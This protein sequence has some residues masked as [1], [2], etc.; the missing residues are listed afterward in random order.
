MDPVYLLPVLAE[1]SWVT[2][3]AQFDGLLAIAFTWVVAGIIWW[4]S[5]RKWRSKQFIH[6]M[7]FSL[8]DVRNGALHLRTLFEDTAEVVLGSAVASEQLIAAAAQTQAGQP[9]LS[10]PDD[11]DWT[12]TLRACLNVLSEKSAS[13]Y[14]AQAV[15]VPVKTATFV[16]GITCEKE[17]AV[18]TR[19]IR[20]ILIAKDLLQKHFVPAAPEPPDAFKLEHPLHKLRIETLKRLGE[21]FT[22]K[23]AV[24]ARMV[25]TV[26]LGVQA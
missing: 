12:F 4:R 19:K 26:E 18:R 1:T 22:S 15:G 14:L 23:D 20:V 13:V 8:N 16:F 21:L 25:R 9:F 10:M 2:T 11:E 7:N 5:R 24:K 17:E 3:L 6:V